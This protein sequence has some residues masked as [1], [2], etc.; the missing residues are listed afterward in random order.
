[1]K[2]A[3]NYNRNNDRIGFNAKF[4]N[5][6][7]E[8]AKELTQGGERLVK[9]LGL[10]GDCFTLIKQEAEATGNHVRATLKFFPIEHKDQVLEVKDVFLGHKIGGRTR[11]FKTSD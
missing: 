6:A 7:V 8:G 10:E 5:F 9:D 1:M 2:I 4:S 11:C 3:N